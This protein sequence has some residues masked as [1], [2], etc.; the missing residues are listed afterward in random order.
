MWE[1]KKKF[2]LNA[3][4]ILLH[5]IRTLFTSP[6]KSKREKF[7]LE[8][9]LESLEEILMWNNKILWTKNN[10]GSFKKE[11]I[12]LYRKLVTTWYPK[13]ISILFFKR[14]KFPTH[15]LTINYLCSD[16]KYGELFFNIHSFMT[17][18][19]TCSFFL[20]LG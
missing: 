6:P 14:K 15:K 9:Q 7:F 2:K 18:L 1:K 19:L 10:S 12:N 3:I 20:F 4:V 11:S 13:Y 8:L 16:L 17:K 5:I